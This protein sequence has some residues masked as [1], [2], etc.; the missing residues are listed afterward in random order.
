MF[1]GHKS[2]RGSGNTSRPRQ[3]ISVGFGCVDLRTYSATHQP[4]RGNSRSRTEPVSP[5]VPA[6]ANGGKVRERSTKSAAGITTPAS[7][8]RFDQFGRSA[9]SLQRLPFRTDETKIA[10][11]NTINTNKHTKI[12]VTLVAPPLTVVEGIAR[13]WNAPI[14]RKEEGPAAPPI[15]TEHRTPDH[16]HCSPAKRRHHPS[17]PSRLRKILTVRGADSKLRLPTLTGFRCIDLRNF[18]KPE[19]RGP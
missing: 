15:C 5:F 3:S 12:H 10:G 4:R 13:A 6:P 18:T 19:A 2:E 14:G 7:A 11:L 17:C 8:H 16:N 1:R 9:G